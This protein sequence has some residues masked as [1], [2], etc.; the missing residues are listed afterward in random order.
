M[1]WEEAVIYFNISDDFKKVY[2]R[3]IICLYDYNYLCQMLNKK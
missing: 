2:I 1:S 3:Y